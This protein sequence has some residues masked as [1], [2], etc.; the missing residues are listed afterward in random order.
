[1]EKTKEEEEKE[2]EKEREK[3]KEKEEQKLDLS[4]EKKILL[5]TNLSIVFV[6]YLIFSAALPF[7]ATEMTVL[8]LSFSLLSLFFLSLFLSSLSLLSLSFLSLSSLSSQLNFSVLFSFSFPFSF[9]GF[10]DCGLDSFF[11]GLV[12]A[13]YPLGMFISSLLTGFFILK[14]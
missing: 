9:Y 6:S 5:F 10:Q 13:S 2:K 14:N 4:G 11:I 3:E 8:F 12:T 7:L 1:M